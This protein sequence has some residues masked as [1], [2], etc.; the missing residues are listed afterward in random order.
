M[1]RHLLPLA[2]HSSAKARSDAVGELIELLDAGKDISFGE[3]LDFAPLFSRLKKQAPLDVDEITAVCV[4]LSAASRTRLM[5]LESKDMCPRLAEMAEHMPDM[6]GLPDEILDKFDENARLVDW[7]SP[8]L[9]ELRQK[10]HGLQGTA[11]TRIEKLVESN[12]MALFLQDDYFTVRGERYV[13]PVKTEYKNKVGGI[14]HHYSDSG[15]TVF[16][17]PPEMVEINNKLLGAKADLER[18]EFKILAGI[19]QKLSNRLEEIK[20][21]LTSMAE[22]DLIRASA[23]LSKELN[24]AIPGEPEDG[25]SWNLPSAR[26]PLLELAGEKVVANDIRLGGGSN[27]LIISGANAGGKTVTLKTLGLLTLMAGTGLHIPAGPGCVLPHPSSIFT[28]MGD[29]QSLLDSKSTFSAHLS[30]IA[31]MAGKANP[32]DLLLLD[33]LAVGTDPEQGSALAVAI[34]EHL[35]EKGAFLAVTSHYFAL[36]A[37][38]ETRDDFENASVTLDPEK[39]RPTYRLS[40]GLPGAS[41]AFRLAEKVGLPGTIIDRASK[42]CGSKAMGMEKLLEDLHERIREVEKEKKAAKQELERIVEKEKQRFSLKEAKLKD[43]EEKL[44][45]QYEKLESLFEQTESK[46]AVLVREAQKKGSL[47]L[48]KKARDQLQEF[49]KQAKSVSGQKGHQANVRASTGSFSIENPSL[50]LPGTKVTIVPLGKPGQVL[51]SPKGGKVNVRLGNIEGRFN[52]SDIRILGDNAEEDKAEDK[53][54]A[55]KLKN[56]K[57]GATFDRHLSLTPAEADLEQAYVTSETTCDVR[58]MRVSEARERVTSFLDDLFRRE[59]PFA[60]IIHGHGTGALRQSVRDLLDNLTYVKDWRQG[61]QSE[62]GNGVT[63]TLLDI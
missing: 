20:D 50:L 6:G 9:A 32:G 2:Q 3:S 7:A 19:S 4:A 51:S 31:E 13:L 30:N 40:Y 63:I 57:H 38:A 59:E 24:A 34:V 48:V 14:V 23:L 42:L 56:N 8:G 33:E 22:L 25:C 26:H 16:L 54:K 11:R 27:V 55:E 10:V 60:M 28:D 15:Q 43:D 45:K 39:N 44:R 1:C 21:I 46:L 37:I 29:D 5:L 58:G 49:K 53:D 47:K 18:E 61:K 62:G 12:Q 36:K 41:N 17:E 35:A 52:L